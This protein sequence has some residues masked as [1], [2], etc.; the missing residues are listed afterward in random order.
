MGA[1]RELG[2]KPRQLGVERCALR[3]P[4]A[5]DAEQRH[6]KQQRW[7]MQQASTKTLEGLD[8]RVRNVHCPV[9]DNGVKSSAVMERQRAL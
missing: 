1:A 6:L 7:L 3:P 5:D 8:A 4:Q 2:E 9:H